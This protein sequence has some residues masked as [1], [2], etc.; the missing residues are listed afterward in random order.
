[1]NMDFEREIVSIYPWL[2]RIARKYCCSIQDAEDLANET[3]YKALLN[4]DNF[5]IGRPL[6]PWCEAIM[7]N[8]YITCYNRKALIHFVNYEDVY[9]IVSH[10]VTSDRILLHELFSIIRRSALRSCCIECV[11]LCAKG[12][13]YC[14][15]SQIMCIPVATVRSRISLGRNVLRKELGIVN[16]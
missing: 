4:R 5:D 8:T 2:V 16:Q 7:I 6:K 14:E 12:Y 13:S 3:V 1:M 9:H 11:I 10:S 15:I